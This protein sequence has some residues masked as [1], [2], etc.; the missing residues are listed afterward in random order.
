[1]DDI[2][3]LAQDMLDQA[4]VVGLPVHLCTM[5]QHLQVRAEVAPEI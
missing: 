4:F 1:M 3:R 5:V 2:R